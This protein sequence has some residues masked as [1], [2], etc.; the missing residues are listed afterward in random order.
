[1]SPPD[2]ILHMDLPTL[3]ACITDLEAKFAQK[4]AAVRT[5]RPVAPPA[6]STTPAPS[7]PLRQERL[8]L[9]RIAM[10][11]KDALA[12]SALPPAW[13]P[14]FL[15]IARVCREGVTPEDRARGDHGT[16]RTWRTPYGGMK[17]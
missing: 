12:S 17:Q 13:R 8:A 6:A 4:A 2:E 16:W 10:L 9:W 5:T 3:E 14:S 11:C 7:R 15:Q 1:M